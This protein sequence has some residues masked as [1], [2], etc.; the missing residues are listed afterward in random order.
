VVLLALGCTLLAGG[1]WLFPTFRPALVV[2]GAVLVLS[3]LALPFQYLRYQRA[4]ATRQ[5][6]RTCGYRWL[7]VTG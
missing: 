1:E 2:L 5:R 6:C 4:Y 7:V 3:P